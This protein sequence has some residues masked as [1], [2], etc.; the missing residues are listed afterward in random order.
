MTAF[1]AVA[2]RNDRALDYRWALLFVALA[3]AVITVMLEL[4]GIQDALLPVALLT[5]RWTQVWVA[6]LGMPVSRDGIELSHEGGFAFEIDAAC[7]AIVPLVLLSAA[8][9]ASTLP[10]RR[11]TFGVACGAAGMILVNQV[12]LV[13]LLWCDA[14]AP[15]WLDPMHDWFWPALLTG[16]GVLYW[17]LL[18]RAATRECHP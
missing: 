3:L 5:A 10:L 8:I 16:V 6:W 7:T 2:A 13:S 1:T 15:R 14:H 9:A 4:P 17:R 11:K 18:H 12:R